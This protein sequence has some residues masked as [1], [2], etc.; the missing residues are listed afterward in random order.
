MTA[1]QIGWTPSGLKAVCLALSTSLQR[2]SEASLRE[3][4]AAEGWQKA[5]DWLQAVEQL[6]AL[7][8]EAIPL[9]QIPPFPLSRAQLQALLASIDRIAEAQAAASSSEVGTTGK[10]VHRSLRR[11][12]S[13]AYVLGAALFA[14][15]T[16][17]VIDAILLRGERSAWYIGLSVGCAVVALA[18]WAFH[19]FHLH[20]HKAVVDKAHVLH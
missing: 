14:S 7:P 9:D 12:L 4:G 18:A 5:Y 17:M 16:I 6:S 8:D 11:A 3:T 1:V 20:T 15:V 10:H 19:L 2:V 13:S